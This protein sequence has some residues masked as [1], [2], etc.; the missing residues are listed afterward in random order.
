MQ[1]VMD[2]LNQIINENDKIVIACSGGPDSMALLSL[3]CNLRKEKHFDIICAHVNHNKRE[4]SEN[5]AKLVEDYCAQNKIIFE[6]TKF[7]DYGK[8]NFEA[9]ARKKRYEFFEKVMKKHE[10][11]KLFTA[12]HGDDLVETIMM[13]L[14][15]GSTLKGYSGFSKY[16]DD[17]WYDLYR[18]LVYVTKKDLLEY[19]DANKIPYAIDKTNQDDSYTRNRFRHYILEDLKKEEPKVNL[20]FL[21][22]SEKIDEAAT[23]IEE[24]VSEKKSK[25][26]IDHCLDLIK[27]GYEKDYIKKMILEQILSEIYDDDVIYLKEKH[28]LMILDA[29]NSNRPNLDVVLPKKMRILKRYS[30]LIFSTSEEI[31]NQYKYLFDHRLELD[32]GVIE[33][34]ESEES[35]SNFVCRLNIEDIQLPLIVR[36]R[37]S[38]DRIHIK[39]MNGTKK[40]KEIF[41]ENHISKEEREKWPILV[42]GHDEILWIPGLKKSKYN[43]QKNEN[44]DIILKYYSKEENNE[45]R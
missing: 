40:V 36:N 11:H 37:I 38:G 7:E 23:Y 14:V 12:H 1:K 10:S 9:I 2:F 44:C 19:V 20:K 34:V 21:K 33:E 15:R 43:K 13:R 3:V 41:I 25:L 8:G 39:G 35:D 24:V 31:S 5:E 16:N 22:Y 18:P 45:T 30:K 29:I 17:E 26:Y 6:Y 4:E 32:N 28:I 42:D 27:F